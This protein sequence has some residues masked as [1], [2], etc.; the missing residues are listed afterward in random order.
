MNSRADQ[1]IRCREVDWKSRWY[2]GLECL[3]AITTPEDG[4]GEGRETERWLKTVRISAKEV[5]VCTVIF[6]AD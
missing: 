6:W 5:E 1:Q 2:W 3:N 4:I